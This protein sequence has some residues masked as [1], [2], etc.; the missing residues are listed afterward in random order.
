MWEQG[1]W[2]LDALTTWP[3]YQSLL[4]TF[5]E[6]AYELNQWEVN[7]SILWSESGRIRR[8]W[9]NLSLKSWCVHGNAVSKTR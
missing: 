3:R 8:L 4:R 9:F 6:T 7:I 5:T 2:N 1:F